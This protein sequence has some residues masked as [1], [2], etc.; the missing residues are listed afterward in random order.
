MKPSEARSIVKQ[1]REEQ[2][3]A[4]ELRV[5]ARAPDIDSDDA[6]VLQVAARAIED[7]TVRWAKLAQKM[8][9]S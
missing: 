5:A 1:L 2:A 7:S 4:Q 3:R 8:A 6:I 9:S